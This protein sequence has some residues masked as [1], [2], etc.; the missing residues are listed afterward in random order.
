M[1]DSLDRADL[2]RAPAS[3]LMHLRWK[4]LAL[5]I[6]LALASIACA[7]LAANWAVERWLPVPVA[8]FRPDPV[9]LHTLVPG[10]RRI[11]AMAADAGGGWFVTAIDSSGFRGRELAT[12]KR[13]PRILVVGDS[14]VLAEN[15]ALEDTF[16]E[17]LA[18]HARREAEGEIEAL[19]SGVTGYGPDQECLKLE[20]EIDALAPDLVVLVLCAHNDFGDLVR[21]KM[22]ALDAQ[23]A[24]VSNAY[25][26]APALLDEFARDAQAS[27]QPALE[28]AFERWFANRGARPPP[29]PSGA[30][31]PPFIEWYLAAS[32]DE[33][34]ELVR[35]RDL[36]VRSLFKDYY[37]ADVALHPE[38]ESS[39][40]KLRLMKAVLA[41]LQQ[42]CRGRRIPLVA[43]VVPS[44][45][46]LC[47]DFDIHVDRAV[48]PTWS[49]TR[50]TDTLAEILRDLGVP[51]V[52]LYGPFQE[53]GPARLFVG[54]SDFHW[55]AAGQDLAARLTAAL[56]REKGLWPPPVG[57]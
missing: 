39:V 18:V 5:R 42:D 54:H 38:C 2:V 17:R 44:A 10:A 56:V 19:N 22:F 28:R 34:A 14:L 31:A 3:S 33:Y 1:R 36:R 49:P 43:V 30:A 57:R 27:A 41:R 46:D 37:D 15:V 26:L 12:P 50:L 53:Q 9:L 45:V 4:K 16:V 6:A 29:R 40:F 55:T 20:R 52:D 13:G 11:T 32:R 51:S 48:Y 47:P 8:L 25:T 23:G 24:L 7:L 35:E 21:N